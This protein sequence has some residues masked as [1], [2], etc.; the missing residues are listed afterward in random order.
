MATLDFNTADFA[1]EKSES[2]SLW[3]AVFSTLHSKVSSY[4]AV[5]VD[6]PDDGLN[7]LTAI[8]VTCVGLK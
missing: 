4:L 8:L 2:P 7:G 3:G 5:G 1:I 6:M